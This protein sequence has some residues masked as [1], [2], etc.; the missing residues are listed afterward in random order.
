MSFNTFTF[1][2]FSLVLVITTTLGNSF[3]VHSFAPDI[4]VVGDKSADAEI[5]LLWNNLTTQIGIRERL[6]APEFSR[7]YALVHISMYDSLLAATGNKLDSN[8]I[9]NDNR[10]SLSHVSSIT[11]AASSTLLYLFPNYVDEIINLKSE[12]IRQLQVGKESSSIIT[13][14]RMIGS[15]VSQAVIQYAKTDDSNLIGNNHT[16]VVAAKNNNCTWNGTNPI[17][18]TA[19]YWSTFILKSGTEIQPQRPALCDSEA[20]LLDLSQ[21][22]EIWKH[23]TPEQV[24]AVHYWG[25]KPPPVIW[26]N[27]LSQQIQKHNNLSIFDIAYVSAYLNAGMSDA[28]VSCWYTKYDYW[29]A[30]PF[31]RIPNITTEIP[32]PNFPSYTSGHSVI[33]MVAS[34]VLGEMFP[35]ERDH[36]RD[37]AIEAGLSRIWAGIHFKQDVVQGMNQGNKIADK[38]VEDM[39]INPHSAFVFNY[40]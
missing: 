15:Q 26:N 16:I 13:A 9:F 8:A 5:V 19:G 38:V 3:T 27:I 25:N 1:S 17:S 39:N 24:A 40:L 21:T 4:H 6:S 34:R 36:F 30:R 33:S 18:P 23:R 11:E 35:N 10:S 20:D 12:Q 37:Q 7:A 28:F 14:G 22:Y 32:T 2:M 31:Q 29:T